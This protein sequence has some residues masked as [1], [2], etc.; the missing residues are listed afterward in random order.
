MVMS[1]GSLWVAWKLCSFIQK[2]GGFDTLTSHQSIRC[3][4][5][6]NS[7][8]MIATSEITILTSKLFEAVSNTSLKWNGCSMGDKSMRGR[9]CYFQF[10]A[11]PLQQQ[12]MEENVLSCCILCNF[13]SLRNPASFKF[14]CIVGEGG[15]LC[16][17][18]L[19]LCLRRDR[20][21]ADTLNV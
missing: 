19:P 18:A 21:S 3:Q 17:S 12:F 20:N 5:L 11:L 10:S 8:S 14:D 6:L 4:A 1:W 16:T 13:S 15:K 7:I 2:R 9:N